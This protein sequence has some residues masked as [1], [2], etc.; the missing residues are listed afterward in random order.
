MRRADKEIDSID[1]IAELIRKCQVCRIGMSRN[2]IPYIVPVSFGF[3]G[4]FIYF[5][6]AKNGLKLEYLAANPKVCFEFEYNVGVITDEIACNWSF[7]FQSVVGF[8][9]VEELIVDEDKST[10]LQ[11]IMQQYSEKHWDFKNISLKNVSVWK[12]VI[13]SMTGK[14][15]L[16][17]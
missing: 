16:N 2:D 9:Q 10:G 5:H 14:Q 4:T 7:E 6:T 11:Q 17:L 8:G 12:I 1:K 3:D 13:A 15:S